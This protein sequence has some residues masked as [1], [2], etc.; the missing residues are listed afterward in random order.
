M[1]GVQTRLHWDP[2]VRDAKI[3]ENPRKHFS[4]LC[5]TNAT[6]PPSNMLNCTLQ[7][8]EADEARAAAVTWQHMHMLMAIHVIGQM[9]SELT[10]MLHLG[11]K[12]HLH[13]SITQKQI[14]NYL[15]K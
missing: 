4:H 14:F 9:T 11:P 6:T 2:C 3:G 5:K 15:K 1:T 7:V 12:L 13:L 10:K 8:E